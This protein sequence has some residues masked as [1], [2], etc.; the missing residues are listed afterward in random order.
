MVNLAIKKSSINF[1]TEVFEDVYDL[2]SYIVSQFEEYSLK[3]LNNNEISDELRKG[4]LDCRKKDS[5]YFMK[6]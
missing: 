5:N 6:I 2:S 4:A 1:K 3:K